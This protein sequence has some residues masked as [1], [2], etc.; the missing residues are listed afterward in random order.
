MSEDNSNNSE[1]NKEENE[2]NITKVK[3]DEMEEENKSELSKTQKS[4]ESKIDLNNEM[5]EENKSELSKTQKSQ[6]SKID[7]N[8]EMETTTNKLQYQN[9][10]YIDEKNDPKDESFDSVTDKNTVLIF[11]SEIQ[12]RKDITEIDIIFLVDTTGSMNP[13]IKG[14]KRFIRKLLFDANKTISQFKIESISVLKFGLV[15]YR[16]HDQ[17][18]ESY[19]SKVLCNLTDNKKEFRESL[20]SL[21]AKGG[22]DEC[23]AVLDGLDEVVNNIK[24]RNDSMKFLYHFCG[25][26]PHGKDINCDAEDNYPD[27][28]P[29]G[30]Q[31]RD[32]IQQLRGKGIEYNIISII[33]DSLQKMMEA[34]SHICKI[35]S[36]DSN[37]ILKEDNVDDSQ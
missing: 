3:S 27:G 2:S 26:P 4:Q 32:I 35:D 21:D 5:E 6:E 16:D 13:Y 37:N 14:I 17:E 25:S 18:N 30:K 1:L 8:N 20:Y 31:Y 11:D 22:E 9:I 10:H 36:M 24:W 15:A 12:F 28:C 33:K 34:F 29:C 23:E 19:V 7:L